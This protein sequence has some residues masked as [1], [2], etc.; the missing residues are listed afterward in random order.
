VPQGNGSSFAG[1]DNRMN[2][3]M[4]DGAY[5]NNSFG[6]RNAP[7]VTAGVAPIPLDA[8]EQMQVN[9]APYDVRQGNFVGAGV[10]AVT[11]SGTNDFTGS[12]YYQYRDDSFVGKNA[13]ELAFNPG[14][15]KYD[16]IGVRLGGPIIRNRLF[17]FANYEKDNLEAPGTTFEA[18]TGGQPV[19]GSVTRVLESDLRDISDFVRDNFGYETGPWQGFNTTTPS[20]RFIGRLDF[21]LNDRNKFSVRYTH[22][23]AVGDNLIS[24]STSLGF[25]NRR[26]NA[27]SMSFQNSGYGQLENIRSIVGE[28]NASLGNNV[29][30]N[31]IVGYTEHDESREPKAGLFPVVD[32]LKDGV[33]YMSLGTDPF[34]PLNQLYY[35]SLQFQ[36]N[37]TIFGNRHDLTFGVS[38]ERYEALNVFF[39][40]SQSVY[41]YNSLEDFYTDANDHLANPNRTTSPVALERFQLR[42]ANQPGATQPEQP[43]EVFYAGVYAQD[44]WRATDRLTVTA[45]VRVDIPRWKE[46]GLENV[47]VPG[48]TFRD[49]T[50]ADV[51]YSTS[52]LPDP[53]P[54]FSPRLGF[55]FDVNGDRST[56]IRGGT[57]VFTG[58]PA[59]VWISNQIGANGM[60]TGFERVNN[61]TARPFNPDIDHHK[62]TNVTGAPASSYELAFTDP[63]F[64]FPQIWRTNIA[65]D[66][67]FGGWTGTAEFLYSRDVNGI[68]YFNANLPAAQSAFTGPDDRPRWT[69]SRIVSNIDNAVVMSNQ[70]VGRSW[71]ISGALERTFSNGFFAKVAYSYGESKNTVDPGSIAFGTWS[72]NAHSGDPNNPGLGFSLNSPGHRAFGAFSWRKQWASFGATTISMFLEGFTQGNASYLFSGDAN[73]DGGSSNDLIY[74]PVDQSEMR[75][76]QYTSGGVTFTPQQQAEAWDAYIEQD[77]YLSTRRGQYAER[78]AVFLPM[79]WRADLSVAQEFFTRFGGKINRFQ[80]RLDVLNFTNLI[81][82]SWGNGDRLVSNTPLTSPSA[83]ANGELQ[84][85]LRAVNGQL[86]SKTFEQ[87][88]GIND[89]FRIGLSLRYMFD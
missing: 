55:N 50:G 67:R 16:Q 88:S 13:G 4:I 43:T 57:G 25:G 1:T 17:F 49:E 22:L 77:E 19:E 48:M 53:K 81:N 11:K 44:E 27:N 72:S 26:T 8:I 80:V 47:N 63:N 65:V 61:T 69:S 29:A 60:L 14:T 45:G 9:I 41:V 75:F 64:K 74:V 79:V 10:N 2:N 78:N 6:L 71:M 52:A 30:N 35:N 5:F 83:N 33:T 3:I 86:M 46:T 56:Q 73:G 85:R 7:G 70:N 84:Y 39:P 76:Q 51:H 82:K 58:R 24:N 18:N 34:T 40:G 15:F 12:V 31:M 21:N 42:W 89:V 23:D 36:N 59:Y 54:H 37:F 38:A 66:Q 87:T 28:W 32:I 20:T 62:P 68:Y